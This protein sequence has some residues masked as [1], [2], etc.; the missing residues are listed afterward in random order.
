VH[1][2]ELFDENT[3][4]LAEQIRTKSRLIETEISQKLTMEDVCYNVDVKDLFTHHKLELAI[5]KGLDPKIVEGLRERKLT[6][7]QRSDLKAAIKS[8]TDEE[9]LSE[10]SVFTPS[11]EEGVVAQIRKGGKFTSSWDVV[12]YAMMMNHNVQVHLEAVFESQD[13]YDKGDPARVP[14]ELLE[15]KQV[16]EE[17]F[18]CD[19]PHAVIEANKK[20]LNGISGDVA[21]RGVKQEQEFHMPHIS[22]HTA[23][24]AQLRTVTKV[25]VEDESAPV[26]DLFSF[27]GKA[28]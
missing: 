26:M 7:N 27:G 5:N 11:S 19:D 4:N 15:M 9:L 24:L 3:T 13:L 20:I 21:E 22:N 16:I 12:S 23:S 14:K 6:K 18:T 2:P 8:L 17:V 1:D 25:D 10:T 28:A